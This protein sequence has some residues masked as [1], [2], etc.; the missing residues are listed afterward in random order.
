MP[1]AAVV[2][3]ERSY[4]DSVLGVLEDLPGVPNWLVRA[5]E[6]LGR[7]RLVF[8]ASALPAR[9]SGL[10]PGGV[11]FELA[12]TSQSP[13]LRFLIDLSDDAGAE[14][15]LSATCAEAG[16]AAHIPGL[17]ELCAG[18]SARSPLY[19]AIGDGLRLYRSIARGGFAR[20]KQLATAASVSDVLDQ[21][22]GRLA[23]IARLLEPMFLGVH[24][25]AGGA[26]S[27]KLYVRGMSQFETFRELLGHCQLGA[28][29]GLFAQ[30]GR[31]LLPGLSRLLCSAHLIEID[32]DHDGNLGVKVDFSIQRHQLR[33][34]EV[35]DRIQSWPG[36][37]MPE[38]Y[39]IVLDR[40]AERVA[41][42]DPLSLHT[43][44]G[45]G[46]SAAAGPRL[47]AYIRPRFGGPGHDGAAAFLSGVIRNTGITGHHIRETAARWGFDA[48]DL[49]VAR[50]DM[51]WTLHANLRGAGVLRVSA[52]LDAQAAIEATTTI[53][54]TRRLA[55]S[56]S[57]G[58]LVLTFEPY[59]EVKDRTA[60]V[61][62][63]AHELLAGTS[64]RRG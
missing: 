23:P 10:T 46:I 37:P 52:A 64:E 25:G 11:P 36:A 17:G 51:G 60:D 21:L 40:L 42:V 63:M 38:A 41:A 6:R 26:R 39:G 9:R 54:D 56:S 47:N 55:F 30:F 5:A 19:A 31:H 59:R 58:R 62:A 45:F 48:T 14:E 43:N 50:E 34:T 16:I 20:A 8:A 49:D 44:V 1:H 4:L 7:E 57:A 32:N 3:R 18:A 13:G 28:F 29:S 2:E 22:L 24:Y 53:R 12:F 35:R 15:R 27:V 33:D 61:E